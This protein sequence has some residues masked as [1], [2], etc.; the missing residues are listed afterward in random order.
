MVR[1]KATQRQLDDI[2]EHIIKGVKLDEFGNY[3]CGCALNPR[4]GTINKMC[5]HHSRGIEN[6]S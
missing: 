1:Y 3:E 6:A 2:K 5:S 4:Y